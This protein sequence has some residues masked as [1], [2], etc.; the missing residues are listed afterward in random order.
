MS[1]NLFKNSTKMKC[2]YN[3]LYLTIIIV[4]SSFTIKQDCTE[5]IDLLPMYGKIKKCDKQIKED[6][7]FIN[8]SLKVYTTRVNA[9]DK[10]KD[11]A[12]K[13]FKKND[14]NGAMKKFNQTWL[15]DSS[16]YNSYW[17]FGNILGRQ[18]KYA[19]AI[20]YFEMARKLNPDNPM[21]YLSSGSG[22]AMLYG[23]TK[24]KSDLITS[25]Q[26]FKKCVSIDSSN[27]EAYAQLTAGYY[28]LT[29]KDS[30]IK[31]LNLT[32]KINSKLIPSGLRKELEKK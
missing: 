9:A 27:G 11:E 10:L 28:Y 31:Y 4:L 13:L 8:N 2:R 12:W 3:I 1:Y 21:F 6:E 32:D 20:S 30:A 29:K 24:K 22:Y 26:D 14:L 16:N 23:K 19:E 17:G 18:K 7:A 5:N 25:I 15:L